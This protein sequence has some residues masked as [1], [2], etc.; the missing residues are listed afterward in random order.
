M[1]KPKKE[2]VLHLIRKHKNRKLYSVTL[3]KTI[4]LKEVLKIFKKEDLKVVDT[5]G[6]DIT[7]DTVLLSILTSETSKNKKALLTHAK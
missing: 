3:H 4:T 7:S 5:H 1:E 6:K 2:S